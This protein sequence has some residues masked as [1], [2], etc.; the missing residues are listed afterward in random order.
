MAEQKFI[1][2]LLD[3]EQAELYDPLDYP[4][5]RKTLYANVRKGVEQRFPLE[6]D[7]Y[8]LAVS[9]LDYEPKQDFSLAEQKQAILENRSLAVPLKGRWTLTDKATGQTVAKTGRQV[10][11]NAPYLT[12]R[13]TF[14][15]N[16]SEMSLSHMFK[17]TPGV[18]TRMR[19]NG[20][21]EAHVNPEQ[22]TGMQFKMELDPDSGVFNV[23]QGTKG[24]HLYPLMKMNNVTDAQLEKAWGKDLVDI[25]RKASKW[26]EPNINT[27]TSMP[28][29][30]KTS[31]DKQDKYTMLNADL[32]KIKL[33]PVSTEQT[34]GR[35]HGAVT[36]DMMLAT[37]GKLLSLSRGE[38]EPD[39]RDSLE[40]QKV[41]GP[42]DYI[43]ERIVRDGGKVARR[44]LWKATSRGNLDFIHGGILNPHIDSVF[45]ESKHS[46]YIEGANPVEA[47]DSSMKIS[48]IGEGGI[49][50]IR[51]APDET[52][53]LQDTFKTFID[54]SRSPESQRVGLDLFLAHGVRKG[55][56]G[57]LYS[58]LMNPK[59]GLVENVDSLQAS[60]SVV[61]DSRSMNSDNKY[62]PCFV[63]SK[64]IQYRPKSDVQYV[65]DDPN[66]MYSF[67]ANLVPAKSGIMMNRLMMGAKYPTQ[68][69]PLVNREAPLVQSR[70]NAEGSYES[71]LGDKIGVRRAKSAGTVM[72]V[73][74][75]AITL[76]NTDGT[77]ENVEL[78][79]NF[80]ANHKGYLRNIPQVKIGDKVTPN[81]VLATSNYT[82]D[83]GVAALGTNL[84]AA[85][86]IW[87]GSVAA[88]TH[89][90]WYDASGS[91][92]YTEIKD[93]VEIDATCAPAVDR[94]SL[95]SH[96]TGISGI[97]KHPAEKLLTIRTSSG[98]ELRATG[99]HSFVIL[100]G[101][102][103]LREIAGSQ[104]T[105]GCRYW[106]PRAGSIDLPVVADSVFLKRTSSRTED[107]TLHLD[108]ASGFLLGMIAAEGC[109]SSKKYVA[110][111]CADPCL[112]RQLQAIAEISGFPVSDTSYI[113]DKNSLIIYDSVFASWCIVNIK[114]GAPHKQVPDCIFGAPIEARLG[115]I[116][117]FWA[118][119]GRCSSKGSVPTD[120][121]TLIT[122]RCLRDGLG[123]L[124]ASVG[125]STTHGNYP[126]AALGNYPQYRL[127]I[128]CRDIHKMP[129]FNHTVKKDRLLAVMASYKNTGTADMIPVT[130]EQAHALRELVRNKKGY[131]SS[132]YT[133]VSALCQ[134]ITSSVEFGRI[135]RRDVLTSVTD[136]V[137]DYPA[138]AALLRVARSPLEWDSITA[139]EEHEYSGIVYDFHME[140][141]NTFMCVDT[142]F[143][144]NSNYEDAIV[145]SESAAKKMTSEH[146]YKH[147]VPV[148]DKVTID[149]EQYRT[150]Y[151]GNFTA[152][153]LRKIEPSGMIKPGTVVTKGDPLV[154]GWRENDPNPGHMG[155]KIKS[156]MSA[157]W[158]HDYD[159]VVVDAVKGDKYNSVYVRA[160]IP[161]EIGDKVSNRFGAKGVISEVVADNQMPLDKDGKPFDIL[162]SPLGLQSRVNPSQLIEAGYGKIA[163]KTGK[164][165][166]LDGFNADDT[167]HMVRKLQEDL[168]ANGLVMNE[169]VTDP[170]TGRV[171]PKIF[172][173][174]IYMY[175][176]K[177]TAESKEAGRGTG[178]Y[179]NEEIPLGGGKEGAKRFGSLE[180]SAL[181]AHDA[182]NVLKDAKL[183]RGQRNDD[184]WRDFRTG[185]IPRQ[186]GEPLV[187]RKF[188]EH[189][190]GAGI[191]V[192]ENADRINIFAMTNKDATELTGGRELLNSLT[193]NPRNYNAEVGGLFD[194]KVFG[195]QGRAWSYIKLDEPLPNPVMEDPLARILN[196]TK[197][198]YNAVVSGQLE[199]KGKTGGEAIRDAL[200][201]I[202]VGREMQSAIID[203]KRNAGGKKD[204][205]IKKYRALASMKAKG[206][207]PQDFIFDRIPVLPPAFRAVTNAGGTNVAADANYLY[208]EVMSARNDLRD[209][210]GI[211]PDKDLA[212]A[213]GA[214]YR[215]YKAMTGLTDPD[216]AKLEAKNVG[217]L[218]QW[219]FG[220][221]SPKLGGFQRKVIGATLDVT[222]RNTV[223]PNPALKLNE[224]GLPEKQAWEIYEPFIVRQMVQRG[225]KPTDAIMA[226]AHKA[227]AAYSALQ[228]V[229]TER[230]VLINRAPTLHRFGIMAFWPKLSK[231]S[232]LQVSPSI[233]V[234]FNMDFDGDA[235]N[236]HVPV[237]Q[238]AVKEAVEKMMPDTN[239][240]SPRDFKAHY[241]P[242]HEYVQGLYLATQKPKSRPTISFKT[243]DEARQAYNRG[244]IAIDTP[245][246]V[247]EK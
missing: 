43:A 157:T 14:I 199:L 227:P 24:Y 185:K 153:Q 163:T 49:S 119:D 218:L 175:K 243:K 92:R 216:N 204:D 77:T 151:P 166:L 178:A 32:M 129:L 8:T 111:A 222:G 98:R 181:A 147:R 105:P 186:P 90:L 226:V 149:R 54:P 26:Q 66:K 110:I 148:D 223:T 6:N 117:G 122:S 190:K 81:Q 75:G 113:N 167:G 132:E 214:L 168:K 161:S 103:G 236:Y 200:S 31:A 94:S 18:Y 126:T 141:L 133:R 11:I 68:A 172:T 241:K 61:S 146:M 205:A 217:G 173:G 234:P 46:G 52:R 33:D 56:D 187:H 209:S 145:I 58:S 10:I 189:L 247:M 139:I 143:V 87:K 9:D 5:V 130:Q 16:G 127:G 100:T 101:G 191:N 202:D 74:P 182:M 215:S 128:S 70:Q 169:D 62:I 47:L 194:P 160:N 162:M 106:L 184:F 219:V 155:R 115:F 13:G 203:I 197:K 84:R 193:F 238:D 156:D 109:L 42:A 198:D 230:P 240:L 37:T 152:E 171:I 245:I 246:N 183:I 224:V 89:V 231:G 96:I 221:N 51:A 118:G 242:R 114:Q 34:L 144:H 159:G 211:L 48:R 39:Y 3:T 112:R 174:S 41:Q 19:N 12:E 192:T 40:F 53:E 15:R 213:R 55:N 150:L 95:L 99:S 20:L 244:E 120:I 28:G 196:L 69:L 64:G 97:S 124:L 104:L 27:Q 232:T 107:K 123:L 179:T 235:A 79:D 158:D 116:A 154:L 71:W 76:Q 237:S 22:G 21:Y 170:G 188:F 59:T 177:H 50:D 73:A 135:S 25:N 195:S 85:Y 63:G 38:A 207:N 82:D 233:V 78:Y 7:R 108:H 225:A 17:L 57:R 131:K 142:L 67:A 45:N 137:A 140:H 228:Q 136:E 180:V 210:K 23:R 36:P 35:Q 239:L 102:G 65:I 80:P 121:D 134:R 93:V 88:D 29:I 165:V 138:L 125:I 164:P 176:L 60:R 30:Q 4:A 2:K 212:E 208:K 86:M 83:K 201:Q 229:I 206:V 1:S 44:L 91:P 72:G 220:K